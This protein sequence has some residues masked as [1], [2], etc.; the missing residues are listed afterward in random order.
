MTG[1]PLWNFEVKYPLSAILWCFFLHGVSWLKLSRRRLTFLPFAFTLPI[2]LQAIFPSCFSSFSM[3]WK[4]LDIHFYSFSSW[5]IQFLQ[6]YSSDMSSPFK[7]RCVFTRNNGKETEKILWQ[8]SSNLKTGFAAILKTLLP[9]TLLS[10]P[11]TSLNPAWLLYPLLINTHIITLHN[12]CVIYILP[13]PLE[14]LQVR[15]PP[16]LARHFGDDALRGESWC[17]KGC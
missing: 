15:H 13:H 17:R 12:A 4:S 3:W 8:N 6:S 10:L 5:F 7:L 1:T 11:P 14:F 2:W 9:S 16:F